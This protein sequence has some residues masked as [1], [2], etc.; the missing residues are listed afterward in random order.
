MAF[1]TNPFPLPHNWIISG[2]NMQLSGL[3]MRYQPRA[4]TTCKPW[5]SFE[6]NLILMASQVLVIIGSVNSLS[7]FPIYSLLLS[8]L[9]HLPNDLEFFS[10]STA[11]ILPY[12]VQNFKMIWQKPP[13]RRQAITLNNSDKNDCQFPAC[14]RRNN[15]VIITSKWCRNIAL[16]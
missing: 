13:V 2:I 15:N 9:S 1:W 6:R 8:D 16:T 7:R 14:T 10:K 3:T 11:V 4:S 5:K 12:S